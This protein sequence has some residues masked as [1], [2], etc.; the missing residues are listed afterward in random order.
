MAIHAPHL[1][2]QIANKPHDITRTN[3]ISNHMRGLYPAL[4]VT[5]LR[6]WP[7]NEY[8]TA[9][10][11]I[12]D[13][14]HNSEK[15]E[16][17]GYSVGHVDV[18]KRNYCGRGTLTILT[19]VNSRMSPVFERPGL[20]LSCRPLLPHPIRGRLPGLLQLPPKRVNLSRQ[21]T[22]LVTVPLR[23]SLTA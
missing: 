22:R 11:L 12:Y 23:V 10:T 19:H 5:Y 17:L 20:G 15:N 1:L 13:S 14:T 3:G 2:I 8:F 7:T 6:S 4:P 16:M 21:A 18:A 9:W